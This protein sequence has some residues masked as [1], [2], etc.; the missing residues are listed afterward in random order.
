MPT[1]SSQIV[2]TRQVEDLLRLLELTPAT[3]ADIQIASVSFGTSQQP[4]Q[5]ADLRRVREKL[6]SLVDA[7]LVVFYEYALGGNPTV[8]DAAAILPTFGT[9][10]SWLEYVYRRRTD[11][12][13]LGLNYTV[14]A[15]TNLVSNHWNT[16]GV[17][18]AGSGSIDPE[19]DSVTN[20]VSTDE[21]PEQF[22]RLRVE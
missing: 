18:D 16:S 5:F 22:I 17:L 4:G 13:A 15:T 21:H 14:E 8:D 19:M 10:G 12:A 1:K 2:R 20:R 7:G 6:E 9:E 3:A 11:H